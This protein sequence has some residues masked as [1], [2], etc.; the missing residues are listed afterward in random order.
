MAHDRQ[1]AY[2]ISYILYV[3]VILLQ[4]YQVYIKLNKN[5]LFLYSTFIV[6]NNNSSSII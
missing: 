5:I 4:V 3:D 6:Y 1:L 2:N